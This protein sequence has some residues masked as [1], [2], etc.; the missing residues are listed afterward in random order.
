LRHLPHSFGL[1]TEHCGQGAAIIL[2]FSH[3]G[4]LSS[5]SSMRYSKATWRRSAGIGQF[6][7]RKRFSRGAGSCR[8]AGRRQFRQPSVPVGAHVCG[9]KLQGSR[10][11]PSL[12][13]RVVLWTATR[14]LCASM[15]FE[16]VAQGP[17]CLA[18]MQAPKGTRSGDRRRLIEVAD[19]D[20]MSMTFTRTLVLAKQR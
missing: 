2:A 18:Q 7:G 19:F 15:L 17:W 4:L 1:S 9:F 12:T 8:R 3:V 14:I 16:I 20:Y 13:C 5:A 10:F 6:R 11:Q